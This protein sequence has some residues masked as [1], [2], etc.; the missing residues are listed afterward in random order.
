MGPWLEL[1]LR[2]G[3]LL[4]LRAWVQISSVSAFCPGAEMS[5]P[6]AGG[7][8]I[9]GTLAGPPAV[10]WLPRAKMAASSAWR[11]VAAGLAS[12]G[13]SLPLA[14][15]HHANSNNSNNVSGHCPGLEGFPVYRALLEPH[16]S[17]P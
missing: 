17:L 9:V 3:W 10:R 5:L 2:Q 14:P 7:G 1:P 8:G 16:L 6:G 15:L 11:R 13:S 4:S 12:A